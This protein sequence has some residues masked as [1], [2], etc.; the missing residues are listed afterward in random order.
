[1]AGRIDRS[2]P[3]QL[4]LPER[5]GLRGEVSIFLVTY[6]AK[7]KGELPYFVQLGVP[8]WG[9]AIAGYVEY[10]N[11]RLAFNKH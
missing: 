7:K 6:L 9:C 10:P 4:T 1:M 8:R 5:G 11:G 2:F 3:R